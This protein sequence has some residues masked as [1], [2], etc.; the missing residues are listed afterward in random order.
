MTEKAES[1]DGHIVTLRG[2]GGRCVRNGA[3]VPVMP[4]MHYGLPPA[5]MV[6]T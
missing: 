3:P 4:R 1:D 5:A 2:A 6:L